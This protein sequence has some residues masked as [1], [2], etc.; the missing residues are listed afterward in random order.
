[1]MFEVTYNQERFI[2]CD[3]YKCAKDYYDKQILKRERSY[4]VL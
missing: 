1:M 2:T 4:P 3:M